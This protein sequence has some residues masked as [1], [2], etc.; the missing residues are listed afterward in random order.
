MSDE[1]SKQTQAVFD[2]HVQA[3]GEGLESVLSDYAEDC[4]LYTP[5]GPKRGL[6]EIRVFLEA[7]MAETLP[8]LLGSF[9]LLRT[10]V[11]GEILYV[12]WK[13]GDVAPLGT[14]TFIIRDNK[15]QVQTFA[16]YIPG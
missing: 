7:F 3:L 13:A 16:A 12:T 4:V 2:H 8:K 15:I 14:D 5:D 11:D 9:E 1:Q 6:A 10:D